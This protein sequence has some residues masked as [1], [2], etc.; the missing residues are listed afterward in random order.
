[1]M[2]ETFFAEVTKQDKSGSHGTLT[3]KEFVH[4]MSVSMKQIKIRLEVRTN[5]TIGFLILIN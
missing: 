5:I 4:F 1:M 3:C 2:G